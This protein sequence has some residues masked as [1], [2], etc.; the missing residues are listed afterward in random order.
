MIKVN[1]V[2][3]VNYN[4]FGSKMIIV[5]QYRYNNATYIDVYF[6]EYDC[7]VKHVEYKQFK[8]GWLRCPYEPRTYSKGYIGEGKHKTRENGEL[9]RQYKI[10]CA[11]LQRCYDPK[12]LEKYPSYNGCKVEDYLL[13]FQNFGEWYDDNYYELENERVELDKDILHKGNKIYSR[14]NCIFVPRRINS[15][16]IKSKNN[17]IG[18]RQ[19]SSG[20]YMAECII[21]GDRF[22]KSY[23]SK[24][25]AFQGYKEFK[26]MKIKEVID[27][28]KGVIPEPYYSRLKEAMYNYKR[29]IND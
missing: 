25:E 29:E 9:T 14:E 24:E 21:G 12:Y 27:S 19:L 6:P 16:F 5:N 28:Y 26:E 7:V 15:L 17:G 8:K 18:V 1:R 10:W 22:N 13:N 20:R 11:M 2:D 3:E 23:D 4:N